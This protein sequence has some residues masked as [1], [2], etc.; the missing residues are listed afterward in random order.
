MA[1]RNPYEWILPSLGL[2]AV[3]C[4]DLTKDL[5]I[6]NAVE[7]ALYA[8]VTGLLTIGGGL[9]LMQKAIGLRAI[10]IYSFCRGVAVAAQEQ[11]RTPGIVGVHTVRQHRCHRLRR[12][13]YVWPD[14]RHHRYSDT[15]A[16]QAGA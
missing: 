5:L 12:G 15:D 14:H 16:G 13:I 4:V 11:R 7:R 9:L 1:K 2:L 3:F 10:A 8:L 6:A